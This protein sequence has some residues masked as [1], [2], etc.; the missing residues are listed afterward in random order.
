MASSIIEKHFPVITL[1]E[2]TRL[3]TIHDKSEKMEQI[4]K[5]EI[6]T[7]I[8]KHKKNK[9]KYQNDNNFIKCI[10][11]EDDLSFIQSIEDDNDD[12]YINQK[13][14]YDKTTEL[15]L[16]V[17]VDLSG[18]DGSCISFKQLFYYHPMLFKFFYFRQTDG[19]EPM[20]ADNYIEYTK[21]VN[22]IQIKNDKIPLFQLLMQID[23]DVVSCGE[24]KHDERKRKLKQ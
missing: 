9:V 17:P 18:V 14:M 22:K 13:L 1:T 24:S 8:K 6:Q 16:S 5:A 2:S 20:F 4:I 10:L 12:H 15:D 19:G 7:I 11:L 21:Y 3:D 23:Y